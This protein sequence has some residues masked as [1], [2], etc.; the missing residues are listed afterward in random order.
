MFRLVIAAADELRCRRLVQAFS[1]VQGFEVVGAATDAAHALVEVRDK[2]PRV[3]LVDLSI[4]PTGGPALVQAIKREA[5]ST[6]VLVL[7]SKAAPS[8]LQE[9]YAAGALGYLLDWQ[10]SRRTSHAWS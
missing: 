1:A 3:V 6:H 8:T 5:P 10:S 4:P 9:A 7:P 2:A